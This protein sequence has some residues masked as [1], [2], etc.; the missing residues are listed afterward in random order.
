MASPLIAGDPAD[1]LAGRL[2]VQGN[3]AR[4]DSDARRADDLLGSS[5]TLI[6]S[7]GDPPDQCDPELLTWFNSIGGTVATLDPA[8]VGHLTDTDGAFT[9]WLQAHDANGVITRPDQYVFG[10]TNDARLTAELLDQLRT[11]LR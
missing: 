5:F 8:I 4:G 2:S 9:E 7:S 3:F 10:S 11:A 1:L 6:I